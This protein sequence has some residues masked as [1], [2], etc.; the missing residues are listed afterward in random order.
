[1]AYRPE[2]KL[3]RKLVC[4]RIADSRFPLFSGEHTARV[5]GRWNPRGLPAIY[6]STTYS[7]AMLEKL[8]QLG[9]SRIPRHQVAIS[10]TIPAGLTVQTYEPDE[11]PDGWNASDYDVSQTVGEKWLAAQKAIA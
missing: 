10:I 9:T 2:R 1:M 8:V 7:G 11:L 3:K 4:Y 6:A 5:G